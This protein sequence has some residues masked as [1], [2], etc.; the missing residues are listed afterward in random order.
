M[1]LHVLNDGAIVDSSANL[2]IKD[3]E[4][5]L[6]FT[7]SEIGHCWFERRRL[8]NVFAEAGVGLGEK[9]KDTRIYINQSVTCS[10]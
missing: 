3:R 7:C 8:K 5:E 10:Y 4:L 9:K 1:A 2:H 6:Y